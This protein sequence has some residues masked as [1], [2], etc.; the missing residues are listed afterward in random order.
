[1]GIATA[2][3]F[4]AEAS[5][6]C[7]AAAPARLGGGAQVAPAILEFEQEEP[8][9]PAPTVA[10]SEKQRAAPGDTAPTK[11]QPAPAANQCKLA[12]LAIA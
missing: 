9:S 8:Q 2:L 10:A 4:M 7:G 5:A 3:I 1:M 12:S 6:M 11:P